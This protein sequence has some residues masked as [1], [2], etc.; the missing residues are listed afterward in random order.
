[1]RYTSVLSTLVGPRNE[2]RRLGFFPCAR[3]R[4]P[5]LERRTFP[6]A[7]ILNRLATDFFV[8]MPLGRRINQFSL[9]K[10]A[11]YKYRCRRAQA[12]ISACRNSMRMSPCKLDKNVPLGRV[13]VAT[14]P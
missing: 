3:W 14:R 8:L 11:Q 4:R 7:V 12:I 13:A 6:L 10:S 1:M 9:Q 2:R 5:A